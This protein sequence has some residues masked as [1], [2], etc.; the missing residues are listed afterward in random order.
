[1]RDDGDIVVDLGV[2]MGMRTKSQSRIEVRTDALSERE[3]EQWVWCMKRTHSCIHKSQQSAW[4]G[5]VE[6]KI[7]GNASQ[8]RAVLV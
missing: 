2:F 7:K 3:S 4:N 8:T 5:R 6:K 1:M